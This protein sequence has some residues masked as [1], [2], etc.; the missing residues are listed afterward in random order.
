MSCA[1]KD[2]LMKNYRD[3]TAGYVKAIKS[4]KKDASALSHSDFSSLR[5][6]AKDCEKKA[7]DARRKLQRHISQHHC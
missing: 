7:E 4:M 1:V 3:F 6:V 2:A 5:A